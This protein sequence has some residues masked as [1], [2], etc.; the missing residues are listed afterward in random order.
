MATYDL[1][2]DADSSVIAGLSAARKHLEELAR[3]DPKVQEGLASLQGAKAAIEDASATARDYAEAID[4][5]PERL[6]EVEDRLALLDRLRR[7]Y[8]NTV[9]EVIV[10]GEEVARKLN[11]LENREEVL[12]ELKEQMDAAAG[13]Y[14]SAAQA[15]SKRRYSAAKELQKLVETEINQLA[16]KAQFRIE[17][18]GSDAPVNCTA[19]GFD[20]VVYLI[21]K[22]EVGGRSKT[23]VRA[24]N[25]AECS[26]E[27][28]RMLSGAKLTDTSRQHAEQLLKANG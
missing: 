14:L 11:E 6:A 4:A 9:D 22:R 20:S 21:E 17:V 2:Y 10:Y 24:L 26:E 28:A 19:S 5:S 13:A 23:L 7:K 25:A 12:R 16:M 8:G 18:S 15:V 1:L 3:F 27:I